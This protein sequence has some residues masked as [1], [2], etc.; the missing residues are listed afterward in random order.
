MTA[1]GEISSLEELEESWRRFDSLV[2]VRDWVNGVAL[3]LLVLLLR[4]SYRDLAWALWTNL[5]WTSALIIVASVVM[6][7]SGIDRSG[8]PVGFWLGLVVGSVGVVFGAGILGA[9][10][11]FFAANEPAALLGPNGFINADTSLVLRHTSV[12]Y[13]PILL[14]ALNELVF[15]VR[16][17]INAHLPGSAHLGGYVGKLIGALVLSGLVGVGLA[18]LFSPAVA[19]VGLAVFYLAWFVFPWR[20]LT[21]E[22]IQDQQSEGRPALY[23]GRMLP[24]KL[25]ERA[26]PLMVIITQVLML[27]FGGFGFT[28]LGLG[29]QKL[30]SHGLALGSALLVLIS[31]PVIAVFVFLAMLTFTLAS[32][33]KRVII[34]ADQVTI[35][36][37]SWDSPD[38]T[39]WRGRLAATFRSRTLRAALSEY[40]QLEQRLE[41]HTSS[42]G[43]DYD[44]HSLVLKHRTDA[45]KDVVVYRAVH[46]RHLELLK[47]HYA[48]LLR[49]TSA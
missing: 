25:S 5:I 34:A 20:M 28:M 32:S 49:V 10:L 7:L 14:L 44:E 2:A 41:R 36:E 48:Q 37:R 4:W 39:T 45:D 21:K 12:R 38:K 16:V 40:T 27:M 47:R 26:G 42:D 30:A 24:L 46:D 29:I 9:L 15:S 6:R 11:S 22:T 33:T 8:H 18:A 13:A 19:N 43:P 3:L 35:H 17:S 23:A 1:V 31:L